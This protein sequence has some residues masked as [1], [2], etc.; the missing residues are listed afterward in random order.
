MENLHLGISRFSHKV[1]RRLHPEKAYDRCSLLYIFPKQI[2]S[3]CAYQEFPHLA[4]HHSEY[5][6]GQDTE[7]RQKNRGMGLLFYLNKGCSP[8]CEGGFI[9]P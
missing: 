6:K 3:R 2:A 1:Q 4:P 8:C 9:L 7:S 5:P